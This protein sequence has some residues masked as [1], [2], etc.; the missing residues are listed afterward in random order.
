[1]TLSVITSE[2]IA[3]RRWIGEIVSEL[4]LLS[5]FLLVVALY[6]IAV[7]ATGY[8]TGF[9]SHIKLTLYTSATGLSMTVGLPVALVIYYLY[10]MI[11]AREKSPIARMGRD[12]RTYIITP[13]ALIGIT[14]PIVVISYFASAF[15]SFK[16]MIGALNPFYLDAT[17]AKVDQ[18]IHFGIQPWR[19]THLFFNDFASAMT[20]NFAYNVWFFIIWG[21]AFCQIFGLMGRQ[22]RAQYLL[23]FVLCWV[24]VGSVLAFILSSAGPCYYGRITGLPDPFAPLMQKLYAIDAPHVASGSYWHLWSLSVQETLWKEQFQSTT[25]IGSGISAMPSMHVS[26]AYLLAFSAMKLGKWFGRVMLAYA[27]VISF[28]SVYLGWHYA[29]DGY[30]SIVVTYLIWRLSGHVVD[31][32]NSEPSKFFS[33]ASIEPAA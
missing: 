23:S 16:G 20:I 2:A 24:I 30:V 21:Y 17:L 8:I 26:M 28:G 25:S 15:S 27:I 12:F 29:V 7:M 5:P 1:V 13:P 18:V 33:R 32:L 22:H 10:L 11:V 6:V 31:R 9:A 19:I 14:V 3:P 4:R